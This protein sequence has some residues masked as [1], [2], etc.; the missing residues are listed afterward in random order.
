[1]HKLDNQ[2]GVLSDVSYFAPERC[3]YRLPAYWRFTIHGTAGMIERQM[4]ADG[5]FL[6]TDTDETPQMVACDAPAYDYFEDFLA[7][8]EG[9]T[10]PGGLDTNTVLRAAQLA[11]LT[12][13]AADENIK[14]LKI[15]A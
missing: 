2:G 14:G 6:A 3:G 1:M 10:P 4:G 7:C 9:R 5:L 13:H 8:I 12:Q 15:P 11:L